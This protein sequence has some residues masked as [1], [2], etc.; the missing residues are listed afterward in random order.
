[1]NVK[2]IIKMNS[3]FTENDFDL[4]ILDSFLNCSIDLKFWVSFYLF[5]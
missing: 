4:I 5:L 2:I 3:V 1:V